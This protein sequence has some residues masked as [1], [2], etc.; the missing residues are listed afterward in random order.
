MTAY[1]QDAVRTPRGKA[2]ADGGL[3]TLKPQQLIAALIESLA[4]GERQAHAPQALILG[5]VGQV[6]AQG[7]NI[8]LVSKL[9]A[10]LP[11][12]AGAWTINNYCA[13]GLTAIGQAANMVSAGGAAA[14][15]AGGVEMM[16][17]VPFM[18]DQADFY[19]DADLPQP[20]RYVPVVVAADRLAEREGISREEM[21][22]VTLASQ[23]KAAGAEGTGLVASRIAINGLSRD[24]CARPTTAKALAALSPA[25]GALAKSY[26]E[27]LGGLE[28][29]HRHTLAHAPPVADGAGLA[30]IT[31]S[32]NGATRGRIVAYAESGGDPAASLTAGFRAMDLAL[33]RASLTLADMD[34]IEF[35]EAFAVTIA[36]FFRDYEVDQARVNVSGGHLAKGHPMGATGAILLSSLLDALDDADGRYGLVVVAGASGVGA[37]MVIERLAASQRRTLAS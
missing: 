12:E 14:V 35:M 27:A 7:G 18:A 16:S 34:R 8:A 23:D 6:G 21:D 13:S 15:L 5:S 33:S 2:K 25:F 4:T 11:D 19:A 1:I 3:A 24:E 22:V 32:P 29:D 10:Q 20:A 28:I 36:K 9:Y 37:A 30:L 17:R 31:A 26:S